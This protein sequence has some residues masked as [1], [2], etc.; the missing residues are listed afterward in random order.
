MDRP[1]EIATGGRGVAQE[2]VPPLELPLP[3]ELE[4][5]DEPL[6]E[7]LEPELEEL[8]PLPDELLLPELLEPVPLEEPLEL[9]E[10]E[11]LDAA[12]LP[13]EA[14]GEEEPEL[15]APSRP[16]TR[17]AVRVWRNGCGID[18]VSSG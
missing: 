3:P 14:A 13:P 4:P 1:L 18:S 17:M 7:L 9:D 12:P 10:P 5:P 8:L 15:Q 2:A 6:L 16:A 11:E